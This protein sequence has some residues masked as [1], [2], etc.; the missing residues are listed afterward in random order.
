LTATLIDPK[1]DTTLLYTV[2][3]ARMAS[4]KEEQV[5]IDEVVKMVGLATANKITFSASLMIAY[6]VKALYGL[7]QITLM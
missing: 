1:T 7:W 3:A 2:Y 6:E 5:T 4:S